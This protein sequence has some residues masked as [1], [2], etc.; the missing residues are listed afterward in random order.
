MT[1]L[2]KCK[3]SHC[4]FLLDLKISFENWKKGQKITWNLPFYY[5]ALCRKDGLLGANP[6]TTE[7]ANLLMSLLLIERVYYLWKNQVSHTLVCFKLVW[8][9]GVKSTDA[10]FYRFM[11]LRTTNILCC[12]GKLL[13]KTIESCQKILET[14]MTELLCCK[15]FVD[16]WNF[17]PCFEKLKI[18]DLFFTPCEKNF[19]KRIWLDIHLL[20][21][22]FRFQIVAIRSL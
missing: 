9:I 15:S 7:L 5:W 4:N 20:C 16:T 6:T 17:G 11:A 12:G 22:Y 14:L 1:K 2:E 10:S 13:C 8:Q 21:Y 3:L 19:S 18:V